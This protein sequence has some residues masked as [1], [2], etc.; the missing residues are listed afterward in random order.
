[1]ELCSSLFVCRTW[2]ATIVHDPTL[3]ATIT[4]NARICAHLVASL[5]QG[6]SQ[7]ER[8]A[9]ILSFYDACIRRSKLVLL[10]ITLDL[11]SFSIWEDEHV[12]RTNL[13][14]LLIL[15]VIKTGKH[16]TRWKEFIWKHYSTFFSAWSVLKCLPRGIPSLQR[17]AITHLRWCREYLEVVHFPNCPNIQTFSLIDIRDDSNGQAPTLF[18]QSGFSS[19]Q[20]LTIGKGWNWQSADLRWVPMFRNIR[21]L[22]LFSFG[23]LTKN[24]RVIAS[25]MCVTLPHLRLLRLPGWVPNEILSPIEPPDHLI[26]VVGA[27]DGTGGSLHSIDTLSG[28][29]VATKMTIL[30]LQWSEHTIKGVLLSSIFKLLHNAPCLEAVYLSPPTEV[31]LGHGLQEFKANHNYSFSIC[32]DGRESLDEYY[33]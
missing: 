2:H 9:R 24:R 13:N 18:Q 16:A 8:L 14:H 12:L 22:T 25:S 15:F 27:S 19:V 7:H 32:A 29:M 23:Q 6:G 4:F 1:M 30:H 33:T 31:M 3:W 11:E 26:V 28:T 17:L 21:T 5:P 10:K 20:D